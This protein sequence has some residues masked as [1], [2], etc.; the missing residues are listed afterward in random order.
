VAIFESAVP[1]LNLC[2]AHGIFAKNPLNL[3]N[4]FHLVIGKLLAK[5]DAI[6]LLESFRHFGRKLQCDARCVCTVTHTL[7]A[8]DLGCLLAEKNPRM[9]MKVPSTSLP[10]HT[11]RASLVSA[12]KN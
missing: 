10:Q 6:P 4:G 12:A 1:L 11:S 8:H 5:F 9:C 7:A 2:D 3:P